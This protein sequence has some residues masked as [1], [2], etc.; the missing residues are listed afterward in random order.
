MVEFTAK[1]LNKLLECVSLME[2]RAEKTRNWWPQR[3]EEI[4][5][6]WN[7]VFQAYKEQSEKESGA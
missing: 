6:L 4:K 5:D 2:E 7:K 3:F 1:E